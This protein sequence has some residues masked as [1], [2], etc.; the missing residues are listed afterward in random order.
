VG[1]AIP[2]NLKRDVQML[3]EIYPEIEIELV[4]RKGNF[5]PDTVD[6]ISKEYGV[7]KNYMFIGAPSAKFPFSMEAL[8]GV[9]ITI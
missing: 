5:S 9:R 7:A 4:L 6:Q 1:A 8:G 2:E 3:D